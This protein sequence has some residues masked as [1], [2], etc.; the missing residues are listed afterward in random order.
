MSRTEVLRPA[1]R[2]KVAT[3]AVAVP[4]LFLTA[5]SGAAGDSGDS[6]AGESPSSAAATASET[7]TPTPT[8]SAKYKPASAEGPAENVPL[9]VMPEEAKVESKE[10]LEAFARYWYDLVNYGFETGDVEPIRAISGPDC[11]VCDTFYLM[12]GKG[13]E[14]DDWI[15]GGQ[16]EVQGV[17]SDF[18]LTPDGRFQVLIRERQETLMYYGPAGLYN[19]YPGAESFGV[20]MI[21]ATHTG[22]SWYAD[23]VVTIQSPPK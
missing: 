10:G 13:Y 2:L 8:P 18:V 14:N 3:A 5:C 17:H 15:V 22:N 11:A 1:V 9:P 16:I 20:Q 21:E 7:P 6:G 12:V 4:L 19:E 23:K